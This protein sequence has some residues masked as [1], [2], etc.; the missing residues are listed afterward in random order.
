M[1]GQYDSA[2]PEKQI[3][4]QA[5]PVRTT[6]LGAAKT[7]KFDKTRRQLTPKA[8]KEIAQSMLYGVVAGNASGN[9]N[10]GRSPQHQQPGQNTPFHTTDNAQQAALALFDQLENK[11]RISA[12]CL[13]GARA[14]P[15]F[16]RSPAVCRLKTRKHVQT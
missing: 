11:G 9:T 15:H 5:M 6:N 13:S 8:R 3:L 12:N 14:T 4:L 16:L 1:H 7:T 2:H 10:R